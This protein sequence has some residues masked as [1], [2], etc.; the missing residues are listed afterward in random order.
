MIGYIKALINLNKA[1]KLEYV[2][3]SVSLIFILVL[4]LH[5]VKPPCYLVVA[6][7]VTHAI[8]ALNINS[9][10]KAFLSILGFFSNK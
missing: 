10:L 2:M 1:S 4:F 9:S 8:S 6:L 5:K 3:S 7:K